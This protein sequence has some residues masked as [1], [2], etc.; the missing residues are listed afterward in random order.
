MF[1]LYCEL[2]KNIYSTFS[3][4]KSRK[5]KKYTVKDSGTVIQGCAINETG[6]ADQSEA[7][8]SIQGDSSYCMFQGKIE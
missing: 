7:S 1:L 2:K 5:H 3:S 6:T 4:H 8:T